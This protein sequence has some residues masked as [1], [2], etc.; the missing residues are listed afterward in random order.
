L[1]VRA[2][3]PTV[4]NYPTDFG[5][6]GLVDWTL[7][8]NY[9]ET[10]ISR[11]APVPTQITSQAPTATFFR[12][13]TLYGFSH[14]APVERLGLTA[15]WSLDQYGVTLR[16]TFIGPQ[17]STSTPNNGGQIIPFN[18][19]GVGLTDGEVRYN[20][21]E[22][23]Q[24]AIGTNSLFNIRPDIQPYAQNGVLTSSVTALNGNN[25]AS[26]VAI[27]GGNGNVNN[28][29]FGSAFNPNGGYYYGRIT[30][31]F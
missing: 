14:S 26:G 6:M 4:A 11:V 19:A 1:N 30:F 25:V 16:E 7:A 24:F 3:W 5:D 22:E 20:I 17:H 18:Q 9:N 28:N 2:G 8:G 21:T 23:L 15:N 29:Y 31:N 10:A 12:P 13:D 27:P